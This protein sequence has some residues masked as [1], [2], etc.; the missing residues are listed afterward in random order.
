[1]NFFRNLSLNLSD[2]NPH[3]C[4]S[5]DSLFDKVPVEI[6]TNVVTSQKRVDDSFLFLFEFFNKL[7]RHP[8]LN[9]SLSHF[10][11]FGEKC[12][13][14]LGR[15]IRS[16][17]LKTIIKVM[18]WLNHDIGWGLDCHYWQLNVLLN[19]WNLQTFENTVYLY[20]IY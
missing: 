7:G 10:V 4:S 19:Q 18:V 6:Y 13:Q 2:W 3:I 11:F 20:L 15:D 8:R 12:D 5:N 1:M 14:F 16:N 9:D 17:D